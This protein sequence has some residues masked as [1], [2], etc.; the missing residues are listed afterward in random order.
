MTTNRDSNPPGVRYSPAPDGDTHHPGAKA[1][2]AG[3]PYREGEELD[4]RN[5]RG[6]GDKRT[7]AQGRGND[8]D[9]D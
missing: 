2:P 1:Q 7:R 6:S 9:P 5:T 8:P 4:P 3:A